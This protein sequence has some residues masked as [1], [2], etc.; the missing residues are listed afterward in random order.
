MNGLLE[1]AFRNR[2]YP[3]LIIPV[4][5]HRIKL[6]ERGFNQTEHLGRHLSRAAGIKFAPRALWR[7]KN[8]APQYT[9]DREERFLNLKDA[10]RADKKKVGRRSILL[11]DDVSTTGATMQAAAKALKKAFAA[12]V[13]AL[14]LAHG[15]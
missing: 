5:L 13:A 8:T 12:R 15:R 3:N 1:E 11:I 14:V 6:R 9:K 4:P 7:V 10:F 2:I